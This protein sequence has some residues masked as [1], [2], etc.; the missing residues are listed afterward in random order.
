MSALF[1]VGMQAE[2][3]LLSWRRTC[4]SL[5]VGSAAVVR[6]TAPDFGVLAILLGSCGVAFAAGAY[7]AAPLGYRRAHDQLRS[8]GTLPASGI[9]IALMSATLLVVGLGCMAYV[10]SDTS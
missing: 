1:D 9:A 4:L 8:K 10:L 7:L 2:R 3:T 6:L 5:G